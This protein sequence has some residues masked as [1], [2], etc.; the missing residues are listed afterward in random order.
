MNSRQDTVANL[1]RSF[2]DKL[3]RE[4]KTLADEL[5]AM[6]A[7]NTKHNRMVTLLGKHAE[8][9][10]RD[11][12]LTDS[13]VERLVHNVNRVLDAANNNCRMS[14]NCVQLD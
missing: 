12:K 2:I 6:E 14:M 1:A 9:I 8:A 7:S 5:K 3:Q 11:I 10:N 4:N 13:E